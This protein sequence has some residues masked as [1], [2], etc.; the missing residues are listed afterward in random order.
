MKAMDEDSG[1]GGGGLPRTSKGLVSQ[2]V[3]NGGGGGC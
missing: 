1:G 2:G 3:K